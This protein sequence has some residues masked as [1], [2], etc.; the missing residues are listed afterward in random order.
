[1]V[2]EVPP[3]RRAKA[4]GR[5]CSDRGGFLNPAVM[6]CTMRF[7]VSVLLLSLVPGS[8]ALLSC[9]GSSSQAEADSASGP[10][11]VIETKAEAVQELP[12]A[13][14]EGVAADVPAE[15]APGETAP[16]TQP[17]DLSDLGEAGGSDQPVTLP[18]KIVDKAAPEAGYPKC[19]IVAHDTWD[20]SW[21]PA[22]PK[23]GNYD[24]EVTFENGQTAMAYFRPWMRFRMPH[25]GTVQKVFVYSAGKETGSLELWLSTGFPGGHYPCLDEATGD[26]PY[27]VGSRFIM[28]MSPEPGWREFD[29]SSLAHTLLG[30]DE[31]FVIFKQIDGARVA[32]SYPAP[33]AP[34]DYGVY[35]GLLAD[36]P[37]DGM[38]CFPSMDNFK[39][40]DGKPLVWL[41]RAGIEADQVLDEH[42]FED[43]L[44]SGPSVGGH[45]SFADYDNDGD[46]DFL[47][48]GTLWQNDGKGQFTDV[49]AKAE[50]L[51]SAGNGIGG[52]S[53]WGDFDNDGN[54]DILM[55]GG[56]P[57]L[58]R[59]NGD[60]TFDEVTAQ[61]GIAI[62]ASSQGVAWLDF[63]NDA[64]LD[65]YAASYG[66]L[67]D[68]EKATRDYLFRNKGDGTF[69]EV[70]AAMGIPVTPLYYHGRG[71]CVA[72]YDGDSDPD[73]YV[74]NYRLD[75]NQL[76]QNQG[77]LNGFKNVA[78]EAGVAGSYSQGAYG[79]SIGP[80]WADLNGDELFDIMLPNLA[81]P[82][83]YTFSDPTT[84]YF[85]DGDG[86]FS[87]VES[88]PFTVPKTGILYDE[89]HSHTT[90]ADFDSDGDVDIFVT[91][92][93]EGR[94][95][96]LYSNAG[97]GSFDDV[98][99][100]AGIKHYNGWGSA[101]A[102]VD[103]DGDVDLVANRPFI[104]TQQAMGQHWLKVK[105]V[106]GATA[107]NSQ[108][109]SNRDA[110]GAVATATVGAMKLVRQ[111]EGG[112]GVG[113]QDSS[114]LH[115]GLGGEEAVDSLLIKWPSGKTTQLKQ[116]QADQ[117]LKVEE[118]M[119]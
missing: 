38:S 107:G 90:L 113:C 87:A 17:A 82:R 51:D 39:D 55:V 103:G 118:G 91:A 12:D 28:E 71:V 101:A 61:A 1:M 64:Y 37:G 50:V 69:E 104:N 56:K 29:V 16:E 109:L 62:D 105:L 116:I 5:R 52:E 18:E 83:F 102:D 75:P 43:K 119:E 94:R 100:E 97:D 76:W 32:L 73:I 25:P 111:V 67:A 74:G 6:P 93:Y 31:F 54:R 47:S 66:T 106:G 86:K 92:V 114:I 7:A 22:G 110:I 99:Y 4:D 44:T 26:D 59:N 42:G 30:Y 24:W 34:G 49:T 81:H 80:G 78:P 20:G 2:D 89:T 58:L 13:P 9:S 95:S 48:G 63:D 117:L 60:G 79:H 33:A 57:W 10:T 77:G 68:S 21:E 11:D 35:G 45:A 8:F 15:A 112:T 84:V 98:T 70:T 3:K 40:K 115:F 23:E 36:G 96:Y 14:A 88:L 41:V 27:T 53:V 19:F 72:D 46:E 85:N 65:F 108:G